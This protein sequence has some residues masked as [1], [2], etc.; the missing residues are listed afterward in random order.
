MKKII[1]GMIIIAATL[2]APFAFAQVA[3]CWPQTCVALSSNA[4]PV[5]QVSSV[6]F[7]YNSQT[8]HTYFYLFDSTGKNISGN[9]SSFFND[10]LVYGRKFWGNP[11]PFPTLLG[12]GDYTVVAIGV[13]SNNAFCG[14]G[15]TLAG[16]RANQ[17]PQTYA[18][19]GIRLVA[20]AASATLGGLRVPTSTANAL[21]ASISNIISGAGFLG[22]LVVSMALPLVF[23]FAKE[24]IA[25]NRHDKKRQ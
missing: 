21:L 14:N 16:C 20:L 17:E 1:L 10:E 5:G 7:T 24:F 3:S 12:A 13:N 2:T 6:S 9:T 23:W 18:Q 25:L 19:T 15:A 11:I 22:I 8:N 4:V